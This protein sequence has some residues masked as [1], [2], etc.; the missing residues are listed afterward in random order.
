[1][2]GGVPERNNFIL[3]LAFVLSIVYIGIKHR[4]QPDNGRET[5]IPLTLTT[6]WKEY[7]IDL[8]QFGGW[9]NLLQGVYIPIEFVFGPTTNNK[10]ETI[11]FRNIQ[12]LP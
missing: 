6:A 10:N 3:A 11:Y 12:Y 8:N 7:Q 1:M 5:K 4:N 9:D 2:V